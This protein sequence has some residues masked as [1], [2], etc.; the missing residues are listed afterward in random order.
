MYIYILCMYIYIYIYKPLTTLH[1][2]VDNS[3]SLFLNFYKM[4]SQFRFN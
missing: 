1:F 2:N 3:Y 4:K